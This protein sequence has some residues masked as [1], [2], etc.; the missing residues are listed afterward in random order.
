MNAS[1]VVLLGG[2]VLTVDPSFSIAEAIAVRGD[3]IVAVGSNAEA[4]A[5]V[6]PDARVVD[7]RGRTVVP[8]M[9]DAH[10]H[11]DALYRQHPVLSDCKSIAEI[12]EKVASYAAKAEP[13]EWLIF[14]RQAEPEPLAPN[15]LKEK[16]F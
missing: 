7:L 1:E 10:P 5:A 14:R 12:Q 11:M 13:G 2:K 9:L 6:G 16:R 8:G 4:R 3:R 15:H